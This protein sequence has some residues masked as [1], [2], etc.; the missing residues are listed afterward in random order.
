MYAWRNKSENN[1]FGFTKKNKKTRK[2]TGRWPAVR[3][4]VGRS[5]I[6]LK[7]YL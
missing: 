1:E 4:N 7:R 2:Y 6:E 3:F 5:R